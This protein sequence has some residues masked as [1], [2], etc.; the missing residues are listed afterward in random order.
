[1]NENKDQMESRSNQATAA[2]EGALDVREAVREAIGEY[3]QTQRSKAEPAYKAELEDERRKR[4]QLE[5]RLNELAAENER[6]RQRAEQA[7][8]D[9]TI[10][11]ELQRLGVSKLDLAFR[12]VKDD[13]VRNDHGRLVAREANG[14]S[15][16]KEYLTRFV[17]ENPE[18]L[19]ARVAGGSGT[20]LS[21]RSPAGGGVDL[22]RIKPG[23]DPDEMERVRREIA[24]IASQT[25]L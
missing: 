7:E 10:R 15:E 17:Q 14:D 3:F 9:T 6:A 2:S 8:R 18:L 21:G 22:D 11:T 12:A 20:S 16:L 25:N 4:E 5:R 1:M 13:V 19:P 24:R 23:M